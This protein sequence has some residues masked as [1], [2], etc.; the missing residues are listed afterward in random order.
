[1]KLSRIAIVGSGVV[2][3]TTAYSLMM[4]N[5]VSK[6][7]LVDVDDIKCKGETLD[8]SD[9][10]SFSSTSDIMMASLAQAGQADIAII[11]AGVPQKIGQ[12]RLDLLKTNSEIIKN[13]IDGMKPLNPDLI[14]IVVTNPV[15]I[16]TYVAQTVSA[17]PKNQVFGSGTLLDTQRVRDLISQKVNIAQQSIHLYTLGEHGDSQIVAWSCAHIAGIPLVDFPG[18]NQNILNEMA[19]VAKRKAYDIIECKGSTAFGIAACVSAYC[20]NIVFDAKKI[21]PVSCYLKE[22][23]VCMSMPVVLGQKGIEQIVTP[24]LNDDEKNLLEQSA[25]LLRSIIAQSVM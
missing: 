23:D 4:R 11:T 2:G 19:D 1:M 16:L 20:Q 12:T 17:L 8:L 10:L 24:A 22:F 13:V 14:V 21:T 6:I 7:M 25:R 15:D 18:L 9:A 5:F 3:S